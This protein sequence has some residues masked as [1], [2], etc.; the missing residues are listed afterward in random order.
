VS[1]QIVPSPSRHTF[2]VLFSME[3]EC[4]KNGNH[5][6]FDLLTKSSEAM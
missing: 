4:L 2:E 3:L 6:L 1:C 5:Q